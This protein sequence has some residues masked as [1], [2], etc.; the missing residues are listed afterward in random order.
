MARLMP[1]VDGVVLSHLE[2]D[3][4]WSDLGVGPAPYPLEVNSHGYTMA[5]RDELGGQVFEALAQ[6]G[7][8]DE[9]DEVDP[10]LNDLLM[11]L[12][13]PAFS[14]DA[15]LIGEVPMRLLAAAGRAEGVLAVLD[16]HEL[17][18]RP[19][20]PHELIDLVIGVIGECAPGPG[21]QVRLPREVFSAAMRAFADTGFLGF[22]RTLADAGV[23]GR[24]T[25]AI[26]TIVDSP[27]IA[28]GQLAANRAQ[29]RSPVLAWY[30][31]AA[32]R[33]AATVENVSGTQ[34]MTLTP[35]DARWLAGCTRGLLDRLAAN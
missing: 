26:A 28:S 4:L 12:A 6:A 10:R 9:Q 21:R 20:Q 5:E 24:D 15:L 7:L 29:A 33:Y 19:A 17:A 31:T 32:G 3:L 11:L 22:E 25:R 30:D 1:T 16:A 35:A 2:F 14:V 8:V 23:R 13:Q 34:W 27:R 18:L